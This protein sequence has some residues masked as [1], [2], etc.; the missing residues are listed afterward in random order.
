MKSVQVLLFATLREQFL[1]NRQTPEYHLVHAKKKV[2]DAKK[3][4]EGYAER[5]N[6]SEERL[7]TLFDEG[8]VMN[9]ALYEDWKK[10]KKKSDMAD[11][12]CMCV[13]F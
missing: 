13:D 9:D 1:I 8:I 5:K 4:D 6:K 11:A 3:G 7:K 2:G 10:A 12:L